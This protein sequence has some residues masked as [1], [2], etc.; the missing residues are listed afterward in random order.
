[1]PFVVAAAD[2]VEEPPKSVGTPSLVLRR[3]AS[4]INK[5]RVESPALTRSPSLESRRVFD[6]DSAKS[7][8]VTKPRSNLVSTV[9]GAAPVQSLEASTP[10]ASV[11]IDPDSVLGS[12]TCSCEFVAL[13][14]KHAFSSTCVFASQTRDLQARPDPT[15]R[16]GRCAL[17]VDP[18][19]HPFRLVRVFCIPR[20]PPQFRLRLPCHQHHLLTTCLGSVRP[21]QRSMKGC[22]GKRA[23]CRHRCRALPALTLTT[24][25]TAASPWAAH[26]A[27]RK[28]ACSSRGDA[29]IRMS[30][31][32]TFLLHL[33]CLAVAV[34]A[35]ARNRQQ[36]RPRGCAQQIPRN[37]GCKALPA[38][39]WCYLFRRLLLQTKFQLPLSQKQLTR[40]SPYHSARYQPRQLCWPQSHRLLANRIRKVSIARARYQW[41]QWG[42]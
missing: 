7:P 36:L 41:R 37:R 2:K 1:M 18:K 35:R 23:T 25:T 16:L 28:P 20:V 38:R 40:V 32:S 15:P 10:C 11:M 14:Q 33:L 29:T 22:R 39:Q 9:T 8:G 19:A 4:L 31:Q 30:A 3:I 27:R 13:K 26:A 24:G 17:S 5:S 21:K 34:G 12:G 42:R 6:P